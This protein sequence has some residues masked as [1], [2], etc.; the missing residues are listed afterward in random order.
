VGNLLW[1]LYNTFIIT[2]GAVCISE[3]L[4]KCSLQVLDMSCNKIGDDGIIGN[5][6]I[7]KLDVSLCDITLT[8]ARSL[9]VGLLVNNSVRILD[10]S[11]NP[12]TAE[13]PHLIPVNC[14][15]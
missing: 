7:S 5:S 13:G 12:I 8:G 11:G 10:V 2:A 1:L 9:A 15:Q 14:I 4:S 3:V 6:Q